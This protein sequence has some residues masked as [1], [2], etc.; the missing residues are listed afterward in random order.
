MSSRDS[1]FSTA[2]TA[3][4]QPTGDLEEKPIAPNIMKVANAFRDQTPAAIKLLKDQTN[5]KL[6]EPQILM[7]E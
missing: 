1:K 4:V 7:T 5:A 6:N 2:E 3:F